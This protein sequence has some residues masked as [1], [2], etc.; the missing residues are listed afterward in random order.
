MVFFNFLQQLEHSQFT[1][2]QRTGLLDDPPSNEAMKLYS[3]INGVSRTGKKLSKAP[4]LKYINRSEY[5]KMKEDMV[6][7]YDSGKLFIQNVVDHLMD[8]KENKKTADFAVGL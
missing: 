6:D 7:F 1:F 3:A 8:C 4:F 5:R 2:G